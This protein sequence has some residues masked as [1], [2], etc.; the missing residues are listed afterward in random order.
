MGVQDDSSNCNLNEVDL[1]K[2]I[3]APLLPFI[4]SLSWS[5]HAA[6]IMQYEN[7]IVGVLLRAP[8]SDFHLWMASC[9]QRL[10]R[11]LA[12]SVLAAHIPTHFAS[13]CPNGPEA[14]WA[15]TDGGREECVAGRPAE[16]CACTDGYYPVGKEGW[17]PRHWGRGYRF[18]CCLGDSTSICGEDR[19]VGILSVALVCIGLIG[20]AVCTFIIHQCQRRQPLTD[21]DLA[22]GEGPLCTKARGFTRQLRSTCGV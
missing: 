1:Q 2:P 18:T 9:P 22:I 7:M 6:L 19:L 14:P 4:R 16:P 21:A 12:A 20:M 5:L 11:I 8:S 10:R 15:C 17:Y 13:V 3:L